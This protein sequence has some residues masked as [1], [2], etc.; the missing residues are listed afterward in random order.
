MQLYLQLE[1]LP[2]GIVNK[3]GETIFPHRLLG[4]VPNLYEQTGSCLLVVN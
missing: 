2:P 1:L 3:E 4:L